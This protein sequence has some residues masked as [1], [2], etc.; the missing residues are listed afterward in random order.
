[1][2]T[3][4]L[5][6]CVVPR[7]VRS[8][9]PFGSEQ[10][11]CPRVLPPTVASPREGAAVHL[12]GCGERRPCPPRGLCLPGRTDTAWRFTPWG[13]RLSAGR[14]R[15][16]GRSWAGP[17]CAPAGAGSASSPLGHAPACWVPGAAWLSVISSG[18]QT[19]PCQFPVESRELGVE[20]GFWR[21]R[22]QGF[23]SV[24]GLLWGVSAEGTWSRLLPFSGAPLSSR[25]FLPR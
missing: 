15:G 14:S 13:F 24:R 3:R 19:V 6:V 23:S 2:R 21:P 22:E 4:C 17:V 18:G 11:P 16:S 10:R 9:G 8:P 12:S 20:G 7:P 1:M 5:H 25:P